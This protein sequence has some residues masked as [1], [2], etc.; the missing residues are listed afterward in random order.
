MQTYKI[1]ASKPTA[2]LVHALHKSGSMFLYQLFWRLSRARKVSFYSSN[3]ERSDEH[4]ICCDLDHDFCLCPIR[5]YSDLP[6]NLPSMCRVKR[7]FH[8]RDPRDILVSQYFS[9]GWRHTEQG[10]DEKTQRQRNIIRASTIDEYVLNQNRVIGPLKERYADLIHRQPCELEQ[11]VRYEEMVLD[12]P[13]Y[14]ERVIEAFDFRS[15]ALVKARFAFRY[16]NEFQPDQKNDGH[17]R[18]VVPGDYLRKLQPATID[19]LNQIFQPELRT[20][21]YLGARDRSALCVG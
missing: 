21:G 14:L 10:F 13:S 12:F 8:V 3:K 11:V 2:I 9:Y 16:R 1:N 7:I 17:K 5:D 20:L 4:E 6:S 19:R 18:S 15:P